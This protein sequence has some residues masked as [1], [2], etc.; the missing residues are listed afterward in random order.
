MLDWGERLCGACRLLPEKSL[1]LSFAL[2]GFGQSASQ[3]VM[4]RKFVRHPPF[5]GMWAS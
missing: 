4:H 2:S 5:W 3:G 1:R